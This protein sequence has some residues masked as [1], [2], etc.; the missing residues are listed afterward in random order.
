MSPPDVFEHYPYPIKLVLSDL[1]GTLTADEQAPLD[2][3]TLRR[4]RALNDRSR[5]SKDYPPLSVVTGRPQPYLE[6]IA[7]FV[8]TPLPSL[9]ESGCGMFLPGRP[10]GQDYVFHASLQNDETAA[11]AAAF[12]AWADR[13]LVSARGAGFIL[14]KRYAMSYAPA[15]A[16]TVEELLAA[17]QGL[18]P[19]IADRFFITRSIGVLDVTPRPVHKGTGVLWLLEY[20][21]RELGQEISPANV[22]AVGDSYNDFPMFE[23]AGIACGVAN[24]APAVRDKV[25]YVS[26]APTGRGVAEIVERAAALNRRLGYV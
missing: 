22:V 24:A 12:K 21:R 14:G 17:T 11:A 13:E 4:V 20:C 19:A 16:S 15:P 23:V 18:P 1:D 7:K 2:C 5:S 10:L 6:A 25:D 26:D 9:F 8:A 3:D